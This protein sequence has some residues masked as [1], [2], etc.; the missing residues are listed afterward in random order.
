MLWHMNSALVLKCNGCGLE[1]WLAEHL[2]KDSVHWR[3]RPGMWNVWGG[4]QDGGMD[5]GV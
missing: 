1:S 2:K 5:W 3:E 4:V